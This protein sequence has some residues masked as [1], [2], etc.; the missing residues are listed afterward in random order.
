MRFQ[1]LKSEIEQQKAEPNETLQ[2]EVQ[3]LQTLYKKL[4]VLFM[5]VV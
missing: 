5:T 1:A 3:D 4:K 2:K